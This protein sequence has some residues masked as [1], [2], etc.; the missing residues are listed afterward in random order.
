MN[1]SIFLIIEEL[2]GIKKG[3]YNSYTI[4]ILDSSDNIV[5]YLKPIDEKLIENELI[6]KKITEWRNENNYAFLTQFKATCER[7][8]NWLTTTVLPDNSQILFMIFDS[9]DQPI[10]HYGLKNITCDSA[11]ADNLLIGIKSIRGPFTLLVIS[12]FLRWAFSC[13]KLQ[14]IS[15]SVLLSNKNSLI[16]NKFH[17][18][19]EK[20]RIPLVREKTNDEIIYCEQINYN[21]PDDWLILLT[22]EKESLR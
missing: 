14:T 12:Y 18:F 6:I 11:E 4:P 13:L 17:G 10:G 2:K 9:N 22:L 19:K 7:T 15:A 16:V 1:S 20:K 21:N 8:K 5:G 3:Q